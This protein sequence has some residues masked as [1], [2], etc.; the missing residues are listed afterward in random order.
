MTFVHRPT[1]LVAT[2][3][4]YSPTDFCLAAWISEKELYVF[5]RVETTSTDK[6]RSAAIVFDAYRVVHKKYAT[7]FHNFTR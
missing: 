5:V 3:A 6:R 4:Y 1:S 2:L 7:R